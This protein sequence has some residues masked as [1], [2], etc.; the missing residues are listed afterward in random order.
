MHEKAYL[1]LCALIG[2][3]AYFLYNG[4]TS[5]GKLR[6][7]LCRKFGAV[8]SGSYQS[9]TIS[10]FWEAYSAAYFSPENADAITWN[11]LDMDDVYDGINACET[12]IGQDYL[13]AMLHETDLPADTLLQRERLMMAMGDVETRLSAQMLLAK[14]GKRISTRLSVLLF[15][16]EPQTFP[17]TGKLILFAILPWMGLLLLPFSAELALVWMLCGMTNNAYQ[18]FQIRRR[19]ENAMETTGYFLSAISCAKKLAKALA[20]PCPTLS[21]KLTESVRPFHG[22]GMSGVLLSAGMQT[23]IMVVAETIGMVTLLPLLQYA[24]TQHILTENRAEMLEVYRLI[25]ETDAAISVLSYRESVDCF[26]VPQVRDAIGVNCTGIVHPL[27]AQ[28]VAN[29]AQITRDWLLTGSNAS[30]KSTFIKAVAVNLILAQTIHTCTARAF[31]F[32]AAPV[33]T[34]MAIADNIIDGESYFVA[35]IKSMRRIVT[36]ADTNCACYCFIDE[37]LKGTNTEERV[38]ASIAVL[39][40]LNGTKVLCM[41]ATHDMELP[42]ALGARYEN[43]HF[44]EQMTADGIAFDYKLKDGVSTTRNAIRLLAYYDFPQDV[45]VKARQLAGEA[46]K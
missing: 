6:R 10:L 23:D 34:S 11:D 25:G 21:R 45:I 43:H 38:A 9:T 40:H 33:I 35:E 20:A 13:Y 41:A 31:A 22:I 24:K 16:T 19:S 37:I 32:G 27:L 1:L 46:S 29:D 4:A 2:L 17:K 28:P 5:K 8:P 12:T 3:A 15:G 39:E 44:C 7:R 26:A 42:D 30:G 36:L 14:L 18:Y